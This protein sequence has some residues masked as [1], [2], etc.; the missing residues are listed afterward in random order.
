VKRAR[1]GIRRAYEPPGRDDGAR[2]LVD[3]LWPR[4]V[5]KASLPLDAWAKEAAPSPRLRKWFGH[6]PARWREFQARY[7]AELDAH[8]DAVEELLRRARRG[9]LTLVYA[10]RD[11]EHNHA[12]ALAAYLRARLARARA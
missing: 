6:D 5:A 11:P 1:I 9:A 2:V 12:L 3:R 4:G 8:P 7:F 10:A